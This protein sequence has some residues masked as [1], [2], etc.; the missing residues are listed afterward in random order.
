MIDLSTLPPMLFV[1]VALIG[2]AV[3]AILWVVLANRQRQR[4]LR[5]T[6]GSAV[7]TEVIVQAIA[8]APSRAPLAGVVDWLAARVP[9]QLGTD[10]VSASRLVHAG[11]DGSAAA[12]VFALLRV[13]SFVLCITLAFVLAPSGD[14]TLYW[15]TIIAGFAIGLLAPTTLLNSK[16]E[17]RMK[18]IRLAIPDA[19]DLLVVCVEAGVSLDASIQRV[20]KEMARLHPL[21]AEELMSMTRRISAGMPREQALHA[22][23]LRTGV[24]ELR[25]LSSHMLQS[26]KWGTSIATVLRLYSDQLRQ[27]RRVAAEKRAATASTRM[28]IPL[29]LFIF[30]TLFVILLGPAVIRIS[31]QF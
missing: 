11:Y 13:A 15:A 1:L 17:A 31:A 19:L 16:A 23:Y 2:V 25:G 24:E 5:R 26:E 29:A 21:L 12:S 8:P 10:T 4:V 6:I 14:I 20:A 3:A 27:K 18:E 28:L 22:L 7:P 30:P 9:A